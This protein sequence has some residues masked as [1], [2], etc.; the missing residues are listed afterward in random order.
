V[1]LATRRVGDH[2]RSPRELTIQAT[3][4]PRSGFLH[5]AKRR[6]RDRPERDACLR[7]APV[8]ATSLR[9]ECWRAGTAAPSSRSRAIATRS[10]P[11]PSL[12]R[13]GGIPTAPVVTLNGINLT[14]PDRLQASGDDAAVTN[15][16]FRPG[17]TRMA[18]LSWRLAR[19][20]LT[21]RGANWSWPTRESSS[22]PISATRSH[23]T[24]R[25][26]VTPG[27]T[28]G[29]AMSITIEMRDRAGKHQLRYGRTDQLATPSAAFSYLARPAAAAPPPHSRYRRNYCGPPDPGWP[30]C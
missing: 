22:S 21:S 14:F 7:S 13:L 11:T 18:S 28:A 4:C 8:M 20:S 27:S 29:D 24:L 15:F 16:C 9:R 2:L 10:S 17:M 25:S 5:R 19:S 30:L 3:L 23:R 6:H 12:R 1:L 26:A